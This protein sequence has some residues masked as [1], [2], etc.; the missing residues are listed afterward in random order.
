MTVTTESNESEDE[1]KTLRALAMGIFGEDNIPIE[2]WSYIIKE[3]EPYNLY[4]RKLIRIPGPRGHVYELYYTSKV[5]EAKSAPGIAW[6]ALDWINNINSLTRPSNI[7]K[8]T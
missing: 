7:N 2:V 1:L 3:I 4:I 8:E 6:A 5:S